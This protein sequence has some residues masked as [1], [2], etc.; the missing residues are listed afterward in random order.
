[1]AEE[2]ERYG[3][4]QGRSGGPAKGN[5]GGPSR[6]SGEGVVRDSGGA[7][8]PVVLVTGIDEVLRASLVAGAMLD[9]PGAVELRYEIDMETGGLRRL[10]VS[11]DAVLEDVVVELD[12]PCVSCAMREDAIPTLDRCADDPRVRGILLAP[13]ISAEPAIVAGTIVDA[14]GRWHLAGAAAVL[15]AGTALEDLLGED[16]LAE[17][18]LQWVAEDGRGVG[19]A[20]AAQIEY[21]DLIVADGGEGADGDGVAAESAVGSAAAAGL[22]LI[23]HLRSAEQRLVTSLHGSQAHTML[24]GILDHVA[25]LR[26]RDPRFVEAHGGPTACGT[27]TMDLHSHRPFHPR[28]FLEEVELLGVGRMR[29]RGRFWVPDRPAAICQWDGAGGQVSIGTAFMTARELPTTRLVV[30]GI[31]AADAMRVRDAFGRCLLTEEEWA[32]GL[33]PWLGVED[34]LAPWLGERGPEQQ[35]R[36]A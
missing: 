18:G 24:G 1:M 13:P 3:A 4:A 25:S 19:E 26:R 36:A 5:G 17:R 23:E 10:V 31:V 29:S 35:D 16:T 28:R 30:T 34:L 14:Q 11:A 9:H 6:G 8:V 12:H 15:A 22:E 27:W 33:A 7:S 20:L 21:S 2:Y 32:A